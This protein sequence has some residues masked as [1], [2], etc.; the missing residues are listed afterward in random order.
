MK[1]TVLRIGG[2]GAEAFIPQVPYQIKESRKKDFWGASK[3]KE[4]FCG[5]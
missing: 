3:Q 2:K 5:Y 4:L 1:T